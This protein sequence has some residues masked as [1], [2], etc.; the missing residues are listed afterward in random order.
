MVGTARP[1]SCGGSSR[2]AR[3]EAPGSPMPD[4]NR[5]CDVFERTQP[6]IYEGD[7]K[8]ILNIFVHPIRHADTSGSSNLLETCRDVNFVAEDTAETTEGAQP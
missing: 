1:L 8:P 3:G 6:A 2:R 4:L 7:L 5:P